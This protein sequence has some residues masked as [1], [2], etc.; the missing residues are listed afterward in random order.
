MYRKNIK[1]MVLLIPI[2]GVMVGLALYVINNKYYIYD[3]IG[4]Y[5]KEKKEYGNISLW[6]DAKTKVYKRKYTTLPVKIGRKD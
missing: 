1:K 5:K 6:D 3:I 2:I 4:D